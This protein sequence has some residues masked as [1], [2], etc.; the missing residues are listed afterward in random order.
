MTTCALCGGACAGADLTPLLRPELAWLWRAVAA[1]ADRRGDPDLV[2]GSAATLTLPGGA[3]ERA[4]VVGVV[5]RTKA[6]QR[7]R[8]PLE[9]L[10]AM[11]RRH[12][13]VLT[14]GA[15]AAHAT[16]RPV[17]Q[18]TARRAAKQLRRDQLLRAFADACS[19]LPELADQADATSEHLRRSGWIA[20]LDPGVHDTAQAESVLRLAVDVVA[21]T[22][23]IPDGERFDRRLLVPSDPHALDDGTQLAG[24]VLAVLQA[25]GRTSTAP[26]VPAR[27]L[28][29][30]VGVDCD[31]LVGGLTM[32]GIAPAGWQIPDGA[33]CTVPP[34][35]LARSAWPGPTLADSW[36]F[37]TENP[38]ILAAA[39]AMADR[40]PGAVS[41][42]VVCTMGTPSTIEIAALSALADAGWRL[43]VRAD[44]DPAGIRH[45]NAILAA[46]GT[47]VSWRMRCPDYLASRP[48]LAGSAP[49]PDA[50]WDAELR[51]AMETTGAAA[52]EEAL[53]PELLDDLSRGRPDPGPISVGGFPSPTTPTGMC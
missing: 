7:T 23:R 16:R 50:S 8:V 34:R 2:T 35:E 37:V 17:G 15:V 12:S 3:A 22:L 25:L 44:F 26:G 9:R 53:L 45:V 20:R 29:A 51:G 48:S 6:G 40:Q 47:A 33:A 21:R 36:I 31:D 41:T 10:V 46:V 43:A 4:A 11:V 38:S 49:V 1:I 28:W 52:F 30:Q 39:A 24:I 13:P 19:R 32:L 14:P 42:R 18:R 5:A 27:T